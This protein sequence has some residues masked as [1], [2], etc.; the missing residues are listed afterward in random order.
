MTRG[1][2]IGQKEM[3]SGKF[4]GRRGSSYLSDSTGHQIEQKKDY[5]RRYRQS[6][7]NGPEHFMS[8]NKL[9]ESSTS[10]R[11]ITINKDAGNL[12]KETVLESNSSNSS[13]SDRNKQTT[14]M[15]SYRFGKQEKKS[16]YQKWKVTQE[17][18]SQ[19][20]RIRSKIVE[21]NKAKTADTKYKPKYFDKQRLSQLA[22]PRKNFKLKLKKRQRFNVSVDV[23]RKFP[24]IGGKR[25]NV[26]L[27][28]TFVNIQKANIFGVKI[29]TIPSLSHDL[30]KYEHTS[31][32]SNSRKLRKTLIYLK[33]INRK[34]LLT[35]KEFFPMT[36][37]FSNAKNSV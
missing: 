12:I 33:R 4:I 17:N 20:Q 6:I 24:E 28:D 30:N 13:I 32:L 8:I 34:A 29:D 37:T 21:E 9:S 10:R 35:S 7:A 31:T 1:S 36:S 23:H 19:I 22:A 14:K 26:G 2:Q 18:K 15:R 3:M 11:G 25:K 16:A 5:V 27:K